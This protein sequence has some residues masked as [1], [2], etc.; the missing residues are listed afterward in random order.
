MA[1]NLV[2][3]WQEGVEECPIIVARV[4]GEHDEYGCRKVIQALAVDGDPKVDDAFAAN[5]A[6][7]WLK[8]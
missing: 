3:R 5:K 8:Y 4:V 2:P 6:H 7:A 1:F